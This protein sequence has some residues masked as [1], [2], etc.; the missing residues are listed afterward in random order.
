MPTFVFKPTADMCPE[1]DMLT[2]GAGTVVAPGV[3]LF[4]HGAAGHLLCFMDRAAL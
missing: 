1:P 3:E 2:V 4:T